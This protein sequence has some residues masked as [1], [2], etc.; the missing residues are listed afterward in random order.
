MNDCIIVDYILSLNNHV[1]T[2]LYNLLWE[3][4][5]LVNNPL[6][7]QFIQQGI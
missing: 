1:H 2:F 3:T 5:T 6:K 7:L 4:K